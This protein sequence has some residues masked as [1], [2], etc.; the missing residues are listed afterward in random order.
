VYRS[1][2]AD[3]F[4]AQLNEIKL[5]MDKLAKENDQGVDKIKNYCD[6]LRNEVQLHLEEL[7]ESLKN[8][9][10]ELIHKIDEYENE[11]MIKFDSKVNMEMDDFLS[12]T[13][14]FHEKW[15]DYL[16]Q[17]EI[18]EEEL[19]L[20]SDEA[21]K[22]KAKLNKESDLFLSKLFHFNLLKFDKNSPDFG[23]LFKTGVE[24]SYFKALAS[25]KSY[26]LSAQVDYRNINKISFKLLSSGDLSVAFRINNEDDFKIGVW[27][28][29]LNRLFQLTI[30]PVVHQDGFH[31]VELN[32]AI[33]L[34]LF[35]GRA[36][37]N[38]GASKSSIVTKFDSNLKLQN[39]V[40][41][42]FEIMDADVHE[43]K[44]YLLAT[45]AK[46]IC[47][48]DES[49]TM[50]EKIQLGK[51]KL[52]QFCVPDSVTKMRVADDFFVFLDGTKVLLMDRVDGMIKR[53]FC[54]GS[55]DFVLDSRNDRIMAYDDEMEKL[56]CFDFQG[57][58]FEFSWEKRRKLELVDFGY[59]RFVFYGANSFSLY[60]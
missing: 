14:Q 41:V 38:A 42:G 55:S 30:K 9:S 11:A 12:E 16:K 5:N 20:A 8:Q 13:R 47:V 48:Y 45:R 36:S 40:E 26:Q 44:L 31:L 1:P 3:A 32:K 52:L 17:F 15:T 25:L 59:E 49:L 58:L 28:H 53:T 18:N 51:S 6:N 46:Q 39:S 23:S 34:C 27:S 22:L 4:E 29:S 21:K 60:F 37:A 56:F 19:K 43:D 10:L 54:I 2:L 33:V 35:D 7:T 50:L 57:G 24:E